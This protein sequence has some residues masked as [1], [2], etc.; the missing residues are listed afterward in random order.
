[1]MWLAVCL[2][3]SL[4][5]RMDDARNLY[6]EIIGASPAD[7]WTTDAMC[8]MGYTYRD[9]NPR[10]AMKWFRK[11]GAGNWEAQVQKD[12]IRNEGVTDETLEF[13][14]QQLIEGVR[15]GE[16]VMKGK[17]GILNEGLGLRDFVRLF[18][19]NP[20][21]GVRQ[22]NALLPQLKAQFPDILPY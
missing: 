13:A 2:R 4:L 6:L 5:N 21:E 15:S 19:A 22:V 3:N 10:E 7:E 20:D 1:K 18:H 8:A 16:S 11:G 14:K 9:E 17:G 12:M